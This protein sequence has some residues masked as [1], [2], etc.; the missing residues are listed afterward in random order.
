MTT[1]LSLT[2]DLART[3]VE[4]LACLLTKLSTNFYQLCCPRLPVRRGSSHG[5]GVGASSLAF[6]EG[7]GGVLL[8][9]IW[10]AQRQKPT[11][12][13][14]CRHLLHGYVRKLVLGFS[15]AASYAYTVF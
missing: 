8:S 4:C 14:Q 10:T 6:R 15:N 1:L 3:L 12:F 2:R 7:I 13:R 9:T 11:V 5:A